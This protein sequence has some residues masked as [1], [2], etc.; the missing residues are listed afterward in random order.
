[1]DDVSA[2]RARTPVVIERQKNCEFV[3]YQSRFKL[4]SLSNNPDGV[5]EDIRENHL[6]LTDARKSCEAEQAERHPDPSSN[7]WWLL[8]SILRGKG[9]FPE[10]DDRLRVWG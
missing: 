10:V 9:F 8:A 7:V 5:R 6:V 2:P 1:M 3:S 4:K